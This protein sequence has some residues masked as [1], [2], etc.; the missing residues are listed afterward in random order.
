MK[1]FLTPKLF[2]FFLYSEDS[3]LLIMCLE[4]QQ[5]QQSQQDADPSSHPTLLA[6]KIPGRANSPGCSAL[7]LYL[8]RALLYAFMSWELCSP[9]FT[10]SA[11]KPCSVPTPT[12]S[13]RALQPQVPQPSPGRLLVSPCLTC[14]VVWLSWSR[15]SSHSPKGRLQAAIWGVLNAPGCQHCRWHRWVVPS[16]GWDP[17]K[18]PPSHAPRLFL[19]SRDIPAA[20][21]KQALRLKL[22]W[23]NN[24]EGRGM[25]AAPKREKVKIE[26]NKTASVPS[27]GAVSFC[28]PGVRVQAATQGTG[29]AV[30]GLLSHLSCPESSSPPQSPGQAQVQALPQ[31]A[32]TSSRA[33]AKPQGSSQLETLIVSAQ[34]FHCCLDEWVQSHNQPWWLLQ[35]SG[36]THCHCKYQHTTDPPLEKASLSSNPRRN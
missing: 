11:H 2:Y 36:F 6:A 13:W 8:L 32:V 18:V 27:P 29:L 22:S 9:P 5:L 31:P 20:Q 15:S 26:Q 19:Q 14:G 23:G 7:C 12:R 35:G 10:H 34:S 33:A 30:H 1:P 16:G 17:S 25:G 3:H 4:L 24:L 28:Q 21:G